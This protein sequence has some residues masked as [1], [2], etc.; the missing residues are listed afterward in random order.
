MRYEAYTEDILPGV[1]R[2]NVFWQPFEG[3]HQPPSMTPMA[4]PEGYQLVGCRIPFWWLSRDIGLYSSGYQLLK[5][6]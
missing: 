3:S 2:Y 1:R 4:C 6:H 5:G